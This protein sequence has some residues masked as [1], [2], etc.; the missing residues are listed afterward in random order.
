MSSKCVYYRPEH[1]A[2][3]WPLKLD[4]EGLGM[5]RWNKPTDLAQRVNEKNVFICLVIMF[6]FRV[7]VIKMSNYGSFLYFLQS[8]GMACDFPEKELKNVKK[9]Q[10]KAKYLKLGQKCTKLEKI[11]KK[12]RWLHAIIA[13]NKLSE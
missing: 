2:N 9:G 4:F 10:K 3:G 6:N 8:N 13:H 1:R 12:G 7:M 5:Q 11:L